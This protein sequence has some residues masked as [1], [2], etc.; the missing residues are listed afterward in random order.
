MDLA[1][2]EETYQPTGP[3]G[4]LPMIRVSDVFTTLYFKYPER[5]S[6]QTVKDAIEK[7]DTGDHLHDKERIPIQAVEA[8]A[9]VRKMVMLGRPGGGKSTLVKPSWPAGELAGRRKAHPFSDGR[10]RTSRFRCGS[11]CA[12]W[13]PGLPMR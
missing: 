13:R 5:R 6:D 11:F 10:M 9:A 3:N 1:V 8:A 12:E 4:E 7:R 2:M